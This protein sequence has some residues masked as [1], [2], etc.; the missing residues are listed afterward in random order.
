MN[1]VL[2]QHEI[3]A[4]LTSLAEGQID[5]DNIKQ[6]NTQQ[7]VRIYD[8][9]RPNKFSQ[10]H[11]G[12]LRNIHENYCRSIK[13][14]LT[15]NLHAVINAKVVSVEQI[16][17][18]EFIRSL[19][20]PTILTVFS[21]K[22]LEGMAL[23]EINPVLTFAMIDRLLGGEGTEFKD[24]RDLTDLEKTVLQS[25][26]EKMV[27]LFKEAWVDVYDI[28]PH[29]TSVETN[30]QFTQIVTA[31][32]MVALTTIEVSIGEVSGL[33]NVCLPF[34]V[35]EPILDKLSAV[36]I[37]SAQAKNGSPESEEAIR[38]KIEAVGLDLVA[39]LG[40]T[41]I[42][43]RDLLELSTGDVIL[44]SQ[45]VHQ[46]LPIYIGDN[47]KFGG[48]PGLYSDHLAVQITEMLA[49]GGKSNG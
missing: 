9:K 28:V 5:S 1:D 29:L 8:F 17:Y 11:I 15:A 20:C 13:T 22:P 31:N 46:Q 10:A 49:E 19:P 41:E 30:P 35:L 2:S 7:R 33:F 37:F 36:S 24:N 3:D 27:G 21:L 16:T 45:G 26:L 47:V 12:F 6:M 39:I 4:L 34:L 25:R 14:Y 40:Q 42:L 44:L 32:E 18:D 43:V 38:K 23:M 48:I